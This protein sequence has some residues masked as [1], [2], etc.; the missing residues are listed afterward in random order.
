MNFE[1]EKDYIMR[2]IKEAVSVMASVLL[3]KKYISVEEQRQNHYEVSGKDL[4]GLL[5]MAD[6]GKINEAENAL[7]GRLDYHNKQEVM[8]AV[9]F[10]QYLSE[11]NDTF[12][13]QN[14]YSKEEVLDG[15]KQLMKKSGYEDLTDM[16]Y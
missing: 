8:A 15:L 14:N 11:K 5:E 6:R 13:T 4:N 2:I 10:Y 3:G 12:L 9:L 1:D 7:L 16:L